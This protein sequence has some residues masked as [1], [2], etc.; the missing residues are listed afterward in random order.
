MFL[1]LLGE[2][3]WTE[4]TLAFEVLPTLV[5]QAKSEGLVNALAEHLEETKEHA[6]RLE[7]VFRAVGAEPSSNFSPPVEKLAEHHDELASSFTDDRLADVFHAAAAATTEHHE[8]AAYEALLRL[9]G[10]L[11]IGD[12]R[13]LL[14][15]NR[16]EEARALERLESELDRLVGALAAQRH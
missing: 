11:D 14:E 5:G 16:D 1:Q 15:H 12:A 13:E 3:L 2:L 8:L 7:P 4:R 10:M 9:G 6:A